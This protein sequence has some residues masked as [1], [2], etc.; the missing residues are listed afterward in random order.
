MVFPE[1]DLYQPC[2]D[3]RHGDQ[4]LIQQNRQQCT[5][6]ASGHSSFFTC[7]SS[8]DREWRRVSL[9]RSTHS[10][11]PARNGSHQTRLQ[12]EDHWERQ[13]G[14]A[15]RGGQRAAGQQARPESHQELEQ[16]GQIQKLEKTTLLKICYT[17]ARSLPE[18]INVL[19]AY[20][21]VSEPDIILI[22]ESW[23]NNN[24]LFS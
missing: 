1:N 4:I 16:R 13:G 3:Q 6:Q 17:N 12:R 7:G 14:V 19:S 10:S 2:R 5:G 24:E 21:S 23:C 15:E 11:S 20:A 9:S 22:C 8:T 18:K